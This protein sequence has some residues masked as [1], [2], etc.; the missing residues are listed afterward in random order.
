MKPK[1]ITAIPKKNITAIY[2]FKKTFN[3]QDDVKSFKVQV[4]ADTRYKFYLNGNE[5]VYGPCKSSE[6]VKCYEEIECAKYLIKGENEIVIKVL[7][8][9]DLDESRPFYVEYF[10]TANHKKAP[11]L[12]F[13]GTLT[14][15]I[16]EEKIVSDES[17]LVSVIDNHYFKAR[18]SMCSGVAPF[19]EVCGEELEVPLKVGVTYTPRL[20]G[21]CI[22]RGGVREKYVLSERPIPL[23]T[24]NEYAPLKIAKEWAY[25]NG[26]YSLL[27]ETG[28]YTTD[29]VRYDFK[30]EKGVEIKVGYAECMLTRDKNGNLFKGV[31]D[32]I[33]GEFD[34]STYDLFECSGSAQT[35]ESFW[36]RTFRFIKVVCSKKPSYFKA[37]SSR[38][39]YDFIGNATNGGVGSFE[40]SNETY[41]K[42]WEISKNTIEC[43]AHETIV[44]CPFYEQAQYISDGWYESLYAWRY[45]NDSQM[46]R[47]LLLDSSHSQQGDG[48]LLTVY[49][50]S[51]D[52]HQN[53]VQTSAYFV[54]A[55]RDYL[56][57]SGDIKFVKSLTGVLDRAL[58]YYDELINKQGL[59][60]YKDG[61]PFIDW[62]AEWDNGVPT[63]GYESPITIASLF[64]AVA[65]ND[66]AE[67][68]EGVG[69][70]GLASEYRVRSKALIK[71]VNKHC[72]D[73]EVGLYVDVVGRKEYSE[74]TAFWAIIAGAIE[75]DDARRLIEK[76]MTTPNIL[77]C[78]FPKNLHLL[79][80]FE[81]AG[82][83]EKYAEKILSRWNIMIENNSTTWWE[84]PVFQRSECHAWASVPLYEMSAMVLGVFP[85]ENGYKKV[86]IKPNPLSL[87]YAKGRVPTT[88][89]YIDVS[90]KKE[91]GKFSLEILSSKPLEMEIVTPSGKVVNIN[92]SEYKTSENI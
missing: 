10:A 63:G 71:A 56:R 1:W 22:G 51:S 41:N 69:R 58:G 72:F 8:V 3:V 11:A 9:V 46:Q 68:C 42:M 60:G 82:V 20:E 5:V 65:L 17:F 57:Y 89:G 7:H 73:K 32:N 70:H 47:K 64:Y 92:A 87:N 13:N 88:F 86:R 75:G 33:D 76:T 24:K 91:N 39:N 43:T 30:A 53:I 26:N 81:K 4:S 40:C 23:L 66:G 52:R 36:F 34:F 85:T 90:W 37:Y 79:R 83:Y 29:Y 44:D 67:I 62:L 27:L 14:T 38:C 50:T 49:P 18:G 54:Y 21:N 25:E 84:D 31:R 6:F 28:R 12:F 35:F 74:H 78:G 61:W 45:S 77:K 48:Q 59:V 80:A 2:A 19:E 55:L 16:G 15:K